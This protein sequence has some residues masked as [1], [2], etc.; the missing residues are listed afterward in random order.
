MW[1]TLIHHLSLQGSNGFGCS[2]IF[3]SMMALLTAFFIALLLGPF[4]I[5]ILQKKLVGQVIREEG[6]QSHYSKKGTPTMGG[7]LILAAITA[8]CLIWGHLTNRYL[9]I[10]LISLLGFGAIGWYDD[11][12]KL[13]LKHSKGLRS[14]WKYFWQSALGLVAAIALYHY[15]SIYNATNLLIPY[16]HWS[17]HI[18]VLFV[19]LA[20][21]VIVGSSN[22][23][24]LTDGLD[25]LAI[26]PTVL[27]AAGLAAFAYLGMDASFA[28]AHHLLSVPAAGEMS[29]FCMAVIGS[30]LGFLWFNA[31]P[32]QL[33]MGDVGALAL[34]AALGV[35]SLV[36][37]QEL[38]LFIM[39]GIFVLETVS[40]ILQVGSFKL[41][42]QK[43][44]FKMA[45]IHHHFEL[46]GWPEPKVVVRFWIISVVLVLIGLANLL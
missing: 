13:I 2:L 46:M 19:I 32:A 11:Y 12:T 16:G 34:G 24:N 37:R 33:F 15:L 31:Y 10:A 45:P 20:Y 21:F 35:V 8:S 41:R 28:N 18:G 30:G 39:G 22:A 27:V 14:R 38:V 5:R 26:V 4:S 25:G 36:V 9:W 23:V 29:V 42:K 40:V 1:I 6:P 3:R 43:R 44:I 7:V 17:I